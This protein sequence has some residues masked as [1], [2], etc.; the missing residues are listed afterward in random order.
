M[1]NFASP[2]IIPTVVKSEQFTLQEASFDLE[3]V[4]FDYSSI[5][6]V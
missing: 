6:F 2:K 4:H 1:P 3:V 5:K